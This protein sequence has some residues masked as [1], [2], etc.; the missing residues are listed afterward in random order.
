VAVLIAALTALAGSLVAFGGATED[1]TQHNGV[2]HSDP[3]Y[4][5]FFVAH[6][7]H[8]LDQIARVVTNGG[9]IAVLL[10]VAV[11]AAAL[12]WSRGLRLGLA[13]APLVSLAVAA[14]ATAATKSVVGRTRP[15][16][17]LH[18]VAETDASFPS[19]HATNSAA[20]FLTIG[21]V[22]AVYV[23]RRPIARTGAVIAAA[24]LSGI[25]GISRLI[26]GVHWPSDVLAGWALGLGAALAVTISLSLLARL[27]PSRPRDSGRTLVRTLTRAV[28]VLTI[29]RQP[30]D[31]AL[32]AA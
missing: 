18:L 5:H 32:E 23:L 1:V 17:S 26:L 9:M 31:N 16:V 21:F 24:M 28:H 10:V 11:L 25:V 8:A 3:A 29:Q 15:P 19:G 13:I 6:R 20:V 12:L 2:T 27:G 4:L 7:S 22:A 14:V 30:R